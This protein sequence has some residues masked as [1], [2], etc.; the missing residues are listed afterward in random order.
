ME[1]GGKGRNWPGGRRRKSVENGQEVVV[2]SF[3]RGCVLGQL[4]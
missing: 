2:K 3:W 4:F 1:G